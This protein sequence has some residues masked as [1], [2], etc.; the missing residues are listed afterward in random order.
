MKP[1]MKKAG[2][3][4]RLISSRSPTCSVD[5]LGVDL[6]HVASLAA[7]DNLDGIR[8]IG[9]CGWRKAG[10][11]IPV[12]T[13][14]E[15]VYR[16]PVALGHEVVHATSTAD[17]TAISTLPPSSPEHPAYLRTPKANCG[18]LDPGPAKNSILHVPILS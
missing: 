16:H 9:I 8:R 18:Y 6:S 7:L 17:T 4:P 13:T 14:Q 12:P 1:T 10:D 15:V 3:I 2:D 5:Q 11:K